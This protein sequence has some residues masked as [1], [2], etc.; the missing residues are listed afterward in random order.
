[1][2]HEMK[3]TF[4]LTNVCNFTCAHCLRDGYVNMKG[5]M[6]NKEFIEK[7]LLEIKEYN[8]KTVITFTGGEPTLHPNFAEIIAKVAEMGYSFAFVSN[9]W[10]FVKKFPSIQKYKG[11]IDN[12][13]FSIDGAEEKTHDTI[14]QK[15]GSYR[16]LMSAIMLCRAHGIPVQLN[17]VVTQQNKN[18]LEQMAMLASKLGVSALGYGHCQETI[19]I[20]GKGIVLSHEERKDVEKEVASIQKIFSTNIYFSGDYYTTDRFSQCEQLRME[21]F[22]IDF[23]GNL[24]LCCLLSHFRGEMSTEDQIANLNKVSFYEAHQMLN[25][26]IAE[27]Q[28]HRLKQLM[29]NSFKDEDNTLCAHCLKYFKKQ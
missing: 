11:N 10:D 29:T 8:R 24:T 7:V 27:L 26:K 22:N 18:E 4:E 12:I 9:G 3:V 2:I 23:L 13:T 21:T 17:M 20:K 16:H 19:D 28:R 1:M 15:E 25:D 6:L 5:N 14:R